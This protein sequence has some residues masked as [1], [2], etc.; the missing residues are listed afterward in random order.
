[1]IRG[2]EKDINITKLQ[3]CPQ[4][5]GAKIKKKAEVMICQSCNGKGFSVKT[6]YQCVVEEPCDKCDGY[7]EFVKS[8]ATCLG[9][10]SVMSNSKLIFK[11]PGGLYDGA[12]IKVK[13]FGNLGPNSTYGDL[14]I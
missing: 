10:G 1:M 6:Y 4:C 8:C 3:I 7:G 5:Q 2:A 9:A 14:N 13:G 11:V 12:V